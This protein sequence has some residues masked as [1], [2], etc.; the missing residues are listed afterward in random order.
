MVA[1]WR[2]SIDNESWQVICQRDFGVGK[3]WKKIPEVEADGEGY[4]HH[5]SEEISHLLHNQQDQFERYQSEFKYAE[6]DM[7]KHKRKL[8]QI[9][10]AVVNHGYTAT[11][12]S[13]RTSLSEV[14]RSVCALLDPMIKAHGKW[15]VPAGKTLGRTPGTTTA[16]GG[17]YPL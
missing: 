1:S 12:K 13:L 2:E 7:T 5:V 4:H 9:R 3:D 16:L 17:T 6:D 10:D 14:L 8:E 11:L 15:Y